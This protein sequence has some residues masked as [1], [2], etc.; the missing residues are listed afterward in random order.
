MDFREVDA[1]LA[2]GSPLLL[3]SALPR[4]RLRARHLD[5]FEQRSNVNPP[6]VAIR[7]G[8]DPGLEEVARIRSA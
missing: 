2:A 6:N 7:C 3:F 5:L 1:A 8:E 4:R